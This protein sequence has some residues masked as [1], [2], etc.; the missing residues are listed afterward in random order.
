MIVLCYLF[1]GNT[2]EYFKSV[3]DYRVIQNKNGGLMGK[4]I[5]SSGE[6]F[7]VSQICIYLSISI[8]IYLFSP[9]LHYGST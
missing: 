1:S 2:K 3:E 6:Y 4:V 7:I 5:Y 8:S 9:V